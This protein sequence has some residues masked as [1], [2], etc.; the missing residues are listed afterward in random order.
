MFDLH[1]SA[2]YPKPPS[3]SAEQ[4]FADYFS[5]FDCI[6]E[7]PYV[8]LEPSLSTNDLFNANHPRISNLDSTPSKSAPDL[9]NPVLQ[10]P[11]VPSA[12]EAR[13][14]WLSS[15]Q[16]SIESHIHDLDGDLP[17]EP[18]PVQIQEIESPPTITRAER[19]QGITSPAT[20]RIIDF[21]GSTGQNNE[22]GFLIQQNTLAAENFITEQNI[23]NVSLI[24]QGKIQ[25]DLQ[26]PLS[27]GNN[28]TN[29]ISQRSPQNH[30][31]ISTYIPPPSSHDLLEVTNS[32]DPN[33]GFNDEM[34]LTDLD[35]SYFLDAGNNMFLPIT[36]M[37]YTGSLDL[38]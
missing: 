3:G 20:S 15:Y 4:L 13:K 38:W 29:Q 14:Q 27:D 24:Q 23:G 10:P 16:N 2:L 34:Q 5:R 17:E 7:P 25:P 8:T 36:D 28:H 31:Q 11:I 18:R 9:D 22:L 30:D 35:I 26:L 37:Q 1:E 21:S 6:E 12:E 33:L 19:I 32:T